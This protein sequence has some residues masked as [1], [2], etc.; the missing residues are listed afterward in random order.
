LAIT[1]ITL[2]E[3]AEYLD[4]ELRGDDQFVITGIASLDLATPSHIS[5]LANSKWNSQLANTKAGCVL[6]ARSNADSYDGNKI[7]LDDPYLGY[8]KL[9]QLLDTTPHPAEGIS[10]SAVIAKSAR[11]SKRAHIGAFVH[12][13]ESAEIDDE[14]VIGSGCYIGKGSRIG[15]GSIIYANVSIY[16]AVQIGSRCIVH[17]G[18]VIGSDGFG[19]ANDGANWVKIPQLGGVIIGDDVEIGANCCIDRGALKP[20]TIG[21]GVKLDNACHIAHNVEI[22]DRVA[23]AA[24]S[25]IAGSSKVGEFAT[26]SGRTSVLGHLD[27]A[28]RTHFTA[29]TL[30]N[31]SIP[32]AGIYSSGTGMQE[33]QKW[34]K[35]VAHFRRLDE[36]AKK[37]KQLSAEIEAL[38]GKINE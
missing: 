36:M 1:S 3:V 22:G 31:K 9:A 27:I 14:V 33:N 17:S 19:F 24:M 6:L 10:P 25:G 23:M 18:T 5:F 4:G 35:N 32:V 8:A 15:K 11:V 13:D 12:I 28:P 38:K 34:R 29:G 2:G 16:H 20:T 26:F 37:M 7:L 21:N 30:V